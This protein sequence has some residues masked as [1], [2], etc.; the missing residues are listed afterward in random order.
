MATDP[1]ETGIGKTE[2]KA[3]SDPFDCNRCGG[4][5]EDRD[6]NGVWYEGSLY[7][8]PCLKVVEYTKAM[9]SSDLKR[10]ASLPRWTIAD[11]ERT[12]KAV[13]KLH[14]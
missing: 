8:R 1:E 7:C 5:F 3:K 2:T 4:R 6:T 11:Q 14:E 13:R 12:E 10:L 9:A